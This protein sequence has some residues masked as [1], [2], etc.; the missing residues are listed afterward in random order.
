M[1]SKVGAIFIY[2]LSHFTLMAL[3]IDRYIFITK[4]LHYPVIM[5]QTKT[6]VMM[7]CTLALATFVS[8]L[9]VFVFKVFA[10]PA[11]GVYEFE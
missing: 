2:S 1:E 11:T 3:T 5:T 9:A 4:P 7:L 8:T 10:N 6:W